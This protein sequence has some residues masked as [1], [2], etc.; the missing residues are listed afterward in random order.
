MSKVSDVVVSW[1]GYPTTPKRDWRF[2]RQPD[3]EVH[4]VG[5]HKTQETIRVPVH[6][7]YLKVNAKMRQAGNPDLIPTTKAGRRI[8]KEIAATFGIDPL[9]NPRCNQHYTMST[10]R[11]EIWML[12]KGKGGHPV[13]IFGFIP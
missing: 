5:V 4:L 2:L 9:I 1:L 11:L 10:H 6:P 7:S 13:T 12:L 3:G 8:L